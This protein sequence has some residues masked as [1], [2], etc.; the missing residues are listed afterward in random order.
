MQELEQILG[1]AKSL[2]EALRAELT[3]AKE[4]TKKATDLETAMK[5]KEQGLNARA[6]RIDELEDLNALRSTLAERQ[7]TIEKDL[8]QFEIEKENRLIEL[9]KMK[10]AQKN[11][12]NERE[13]LV[14]LYEERLQLQKEREILEKEKKEYKEKLSKDFQKKMLKGK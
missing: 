5:V 12:E 1:T 6:K 11:L 8:N 13:S 3:K 4:Q 9:D 14:P 2:A 10:K 7:K